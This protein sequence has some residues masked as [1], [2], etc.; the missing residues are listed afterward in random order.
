MT[1]PQHDPNLLAYLQ[2]WR[3]YLEQVASAAVAPGFP[4]PAVPQ[5]PLPAMPLV[6][7]PLPPM[8]P[9][10]ANPTSA[11]F[12]PPPNQPTMASADH[13]Q[14][15]L[16]ALQAWRQF[17]EQSL[18]GAAAGGAEPATDESSLRKKDRVPPLID[19]LSRVADAA[20]AA[21]AGQTLSRAAPDYRTPS[22]RVGSAYAPESGAPAVYGGSAGTTPRSLYSAAA[23][24][25]PVPETEWW[26]SPTN[27][28]TPPTE[29][30]GRQSQQSKPAPDADQ[31][32]SDA[33]D[34][35]GDKSEESTFPPPKWQELVGPRDTG[36]SFHPASPWTQRAAALSTVRPANDLQIPSLPRRSR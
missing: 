33:G 11:A 32:Q 28:A 30:G 24:P 16:T 19:D 26:N 22:P 15:L 25:D 8:P 35:D 27:V 7:P 21:D 4:F 12:G 31:T 6:P 3:Q 36:G 20:A 5:L 1:M 14:Q 23:E 13:V 2:A 17:L 10:F 18:G 34:R 29:G 9:G